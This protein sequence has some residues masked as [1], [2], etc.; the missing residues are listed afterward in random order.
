MFFGEPSLLFSAFI[1]F[2]LG[3]I[4]NLK[5]QDF[6]IFQISFL[7]LNIFSVLLSWHFYQVNNQ[8]FDVGGDDKYFFDEWILKGYY[9]FDDVLVDYNPYKTFVIPSAV[10]FKFINLI[11]LNS[12]FSYHINLLN[13]FLASFIPVYTYKLGKLIFTPITAQRASLFVLFY[14]FFNFQCAKIIRDGYVYLI[15]LMIVYF[16]A[17]QISH[18]RKIIAILFLSILMFNLRKEAI[19]YIIVLSGSYIYTFVTQK[20]YKILLLVILATAALFI[21]FTLNYKYGLDFNSI[22]RFSE[23]YDELREETSGGISLATKIKNAGF[24]GKVISVPYVWFSPLPPP[25]IASLTFIN[26]LISIGVLFWYY[27]LP[28]GGIQLYQTALNSLDRSKKSISIAILVTFLIGSLF[29]SY[30]S[31]DPRHIM[32]FMPIATIYCFSYYEFNSFY[33]E[34]NLNKSLFIIFGLGALLYS[35]LKY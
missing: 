26:F 30:T 33:N 9:D 25:V 24:V 21:A 27:L 13:I 6:V 35:I 10:Y 34:M 3:S 14:P 19:I 28:R 18:L 22:N 15:F 11:G 12:T 1:F 17:S 31:G 4:I 20:K 7:W 16:M 23:L 5:N 29:I 8:L 2:I 32:I